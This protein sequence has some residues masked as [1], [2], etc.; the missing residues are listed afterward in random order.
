MGA[1]GRGSFDNDDALDWL[2]E[3]T[4]SD[5]VN[6]IVGAFDAVERSGNEYLE[7]PEAAA[8]LAA[9]EVVAAARGRPAPILPTSVQEFLAKQPRI[10]RRLAERARRVVGQV[11]RA[12]EL[13]DLYTE[14]GTAGEWRELVKNLE[15]RLTQTLGM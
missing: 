14:A 8:G 11:G 2:G 7:A 15:D 12:S 3:L 10:D 9:A 1:W 5:D 6:P 4:V 13:A